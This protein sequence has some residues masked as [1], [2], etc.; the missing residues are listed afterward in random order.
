MRF[1]PAS[2]E[3]GRSRFNGGHA[4]LALVTP[5]MGQGAHPRGKRGTFRKMTVLT[6]VHTGVSRHRNGTGNFYEDVEFLPGYN[7]TTNEATGK[8]G[9]FE[10]DLHGNVN[11]LLGGAML[12]GVVMVVVLM[13]YCCH[14]NMRKSRPQEYSPYWR[15]EPDGHSLEVFTTDAHAMCYDRQATMVGSQD[16]NTYGP[17]SCPATPGSGPGPPP[18]YDS[19]IFNQQSLPV[20]IEKKLDSPGTPGTIIPSVMST[21]LSLA[22]NTPVQRPISDTDPVEPAEH[23]LSNASDEGLPSYEAALKLDANGYV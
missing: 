11:I 1:S 15:T 18:A 21:I 7:V 2:D 13:C 9:R 3:E 4:A 6:A 19:L 20:S 14:K 10:T 5:T 8:T 17:L 22:S 12:S 16:E 23:R